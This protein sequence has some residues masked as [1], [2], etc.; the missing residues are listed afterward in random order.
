MTHNPEPEVDFILQAI[1]DNYGKAMADIPLDRID[2]DNAR[3]LDAD[4]R[5]KTEAYQVSNFVG[6]STETTDNEVLG[7]DFN[8]KVQAVVNVRISGGSYVEGGHI[9]PEGNDGV[10]WRDL[11]RNIR[12][13]IMEEREFPSVSNRSNRTYTW[14]DERNPNDLSA[15][16]AD[17]YRFTADYVFIGNE[18][19]P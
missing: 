16:F 7:K 8:Q 19:L 11:K 1:K 4:R 6:A 13:A 15:E 2:R 12:R 17:E 9:D 10:I 3:N 14:I 18:D 5:D